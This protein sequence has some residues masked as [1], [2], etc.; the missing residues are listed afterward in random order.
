MLS[1]NWKCRIERKTHSP[2]QTHPSPCLPFPPIPLSPHLFLL[3][4][5]YVCLC[6]CVHE[7]GCVCLC[8]CVWGVYLRCVVECAFDCVPPVTLTWALAVLEQYHMSPQGNPTPT[9]VC[10]SGYCRVCVCVLEGMS[11]VLECITVEEC[12]PAPD[13]RAVED[14]GQIDELWKSRAR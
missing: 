11:Y 9:A 2:F 3:I 8:L 6:A 4:W 13:R 5:K 12:R 7:C 14:Q 10:S 1:H